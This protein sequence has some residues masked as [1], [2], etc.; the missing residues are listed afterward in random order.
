MIGRSKKQDARGKIL[1]LIRGV[2]K[3]AVCA[4]HYW[5]IAF[6][7]STQ[8]MKNQMFVYLACLLLLLDIIIVTMFFRG[9]NMSAFALYTIYEKLKMICWLQAP[10]FGLQP[11]VVRSL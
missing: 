4:L 7:H 1:F 10:G 11:A 8:R 2:L 5:V 9:V 3:S 6:S